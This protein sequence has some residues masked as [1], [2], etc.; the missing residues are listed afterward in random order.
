M[1]VLN[2][3]VAVYIPESDTEGNYYVDSRFM[4]DYFDVNEVLGNAIESNFADADF[5]GEEPSG[6]LVRKTRT[7]NDKYFARLGRK[8]T[9]FYNLDAVSKED[10]VLVFGDLVKNLFYVQG[11]DIIN[12]EINDS[13]IQILRDELEELDNVM[14]DLL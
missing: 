4:D 8:V 11:A 2:K 13:F 6:L 12:I 5:T 7:M 1:L 9:W 10:I 3:K 14:K